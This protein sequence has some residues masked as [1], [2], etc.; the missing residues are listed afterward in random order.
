MHNN[1]LVIAVPV[2]CQGLL[3]LSLCW[4]YEQSGAGGEDW[5]GGQLGYLPQTDQRYISSLI[6]WHSEVKLGGVLPQEVSTWLGIRLQ[7][8]TACLC[9]TWLFL[10]LFNFI[11][12]PDC[13]YLDSQVFLP[14]ALQVLSPILLGREGVGA[15]LPDRV[16][17]PQCP[18]QSRVCGVT[19]WCSLL[20]GSDHSSAVWSALL[21]FQI[22]KAS[23]RSW[24]LALLVEGVKEAKSSRFHTSNRRNAAH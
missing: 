8:V 14:L 10:G 1:V 24:G 3:H 12:L 7:V 16:S 6:M 21:T 15:E 11:F 4:P 13:L 5:E 2:Q 19:G 9:I 20:P 22:L 18:K 17:P 23:V